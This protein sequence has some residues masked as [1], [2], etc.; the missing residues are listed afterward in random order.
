MYHELFQPSMLLP[1]YKKTW[2]QILWPYPENGIY[3]ALY[4]KVVSCWDIYHLDKRTEREAFFDDFGNAETLLA[5]LTQEGHHPT[6]ATI[7]RSSDGDVLALLLFERFPP[8]DYEFLNILN[9]L[10]G[11]SLHDYFNRSEIKKLENTYENVMKTLQNV[12]ELFVEARKT[13]GLSG[14]LEMAERFFSNQFQTTGLYLLFSKDSKPILIPENTNPVIS[15]KLFQHYED[16]SEE[17]WMDYLPE[18]GTI[19]FTLPASHKGK[20]LFSV[21]KAATKPRSVF[22]PT[23]E[24][25][26]QKIYWRRLSLIDGRMTM[27]K[28]PL[29]L[30]GTQLVRSDASEKV[31]GAAKY[32]DDLHFSD[33]VY[34]AIRTAEVA[35]GALRSIDISKARGSHGV[36]AVLTHADIPGE[37]QMGSPVPDYPILLKPGDEIRYVGDYVAFVV[38][39]TREQALRAAEKV[40]IMVAEKKPVLSLNERIRELQKG[41]DYVPAVHQKIRK[42]DSDP[43]TMF[44]SCDYV[45]EGDFFA[46]Y[47]EHAYLE[48]QGMIAL[49]D[50]DNVMTI[51]GSMQCPY[52]VQ[53][54]VARA[55]AFP[56]MDTHHRS[57]P[58]AFGGKEVPFISPYPQL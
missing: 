45:F 37:N 36:L 51:Y 19:L 33:T 31:L 20:H 55:S 1:Y 30:I 42:G 49:Y 32:V 29:T 40:T 8:Q 43:K 28:N 53:N 56:S 22:D 9:A 34:L 16:Q 21:W 13:V 11:L 14:F 52:Y 15:E 4:V 46:D 44:D 48:T 35:S 54:G 38:A 10:T 24:I 2:S 26:V 50:Q 25:G 5:V 12:N 58:E 23:I 47:Q 57:V 17:L 7:L 6:L 18:T 3:P 39:H 27:E 41:G